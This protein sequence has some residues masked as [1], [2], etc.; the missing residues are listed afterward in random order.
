MVM[1]G[2]NQRSDGFIIIVEY[3]YSKADFF[4]IRKRIAYPRDESLKKIHIIS[5]YV[6]IRVDIKLY[7]R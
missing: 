5:E 2:V 1:Q 3:R 4:L 6:K 7:I